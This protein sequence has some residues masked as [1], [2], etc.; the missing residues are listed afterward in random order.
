MNF[1]KKFNR[2]DRLAVIMN[3]LT[4]RTNEIFTYNY[5]NN[6]FDTAK[7]SIS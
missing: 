3:I 6:I 4:E 7:S 1:V 2:K 5:F